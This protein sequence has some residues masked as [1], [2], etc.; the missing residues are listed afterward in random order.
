MATSNQH[1]KTEVGGANSN[2]PE[3]AK[4]VHAKKHASN[5]VT[6]ARQH[7]G[8][9][10]RDNPDHARHDTNA[11]IQNSRATPGAEFRESFPKPH[12]GHKGG[13]R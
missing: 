6:G 1:R 3:K 13:N 2:D 11:T 12:P 8:G 10:E 5:S 7:V 4:K 9:Q